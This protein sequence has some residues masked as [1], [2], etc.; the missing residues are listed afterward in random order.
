MH[1]SYYQWI[2]E[3]MQRA[4]TLMCFT[5]ITQ[6]D[7]TFIVHGTVHN[8][9]IQMI[10]DNGAFVVTLVPSRRDT[11]TRW[12]SSM[13]RLFV[14]SVI[15]VDFVFAMCVLTSTKQCQ[16]KP[17]HKIQAAI[18]QR[19]STLAIP[20]RL[21]QK[22]RPKRKRKRNRHIFC[23]YA[24]FVLLL[25]LFHTFFA[26]SLHQWDCFLY[27]NL[28]I[29]KLVFVQFFFSSLLLIIYLHG[30][31]LWLSPHRLRICPHCYLFGYFIKR[32]L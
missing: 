32:K 9:T 28:Q 14:P 24:L 1:S 18:S 17:T 27:N 11:I 7:N 10:T 15:F 30:T 2:C 31:F 12:P 4:F 23:S 5:Y 29:T 25:L 20:E 3:Q 22:R 16:T 19:N 26:R 21:Q 8:I 6:S 13:I